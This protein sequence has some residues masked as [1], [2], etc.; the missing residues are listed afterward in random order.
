MIDLTSLS[1]SQVNKS[2]SSKSISPLEPVGSNKSLATTMP[3]E[4]QTSLGLSNVDVARES[5]GN[6]EQWK[7]SKIFHPK[8]SKSALTSENFL[9]ARAAYEPIY[10]HNVA[11]TKLALMSIM[12]KEKPRYSEQIN[13]LA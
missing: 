1:G 10:M 8:Q 3:S 5:A 2:A 9:R 4:R 12:D 11:A 13:I 7:K 6:Y